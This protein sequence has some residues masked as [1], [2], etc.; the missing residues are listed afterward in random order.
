[1][2]L[3]LILSAA[4]HPARSQPGSSFERERGLIMLDS[5]KSDLKKN[6]YDAN[7]HGMDL[8]ARFKQAEEKIKQAASNGQ[9]FSIIAQ[10]LSELEDSHTFFLPPSR[11]GR[12]DYGWQMQ[13][14]GDKCY[15]TAIRP[16]SDAE[17]K[18]L[19]LG[20]EVWTIDGFGLTRENL[21]KLKY[22]YYSLK[23]RGGMRVVVKKPDGQEQQLDVMA[24]VVSGK[25]VI[26]LTGNDIVQFIR[27]AESEDRL[28]RHRYYE[29]GDELMIWK[30]PQFDLTDL[31]VDEIM[32]KV[33]KRKALV[34]DLRGNGGG[35]ISTLQRLVGNL[36]D[37]DIKIGDVK[38]RNEMK[39]QVG[40]T[41][42]QKAY[43]GKLV[44]LVD[45]ES[46][47]ASELFA[48]IVQLEKRGTVIGD[49]TAGAVM[50]SKHYSHQLGIDTIA[51]YGVSVTNA[52][53]IMSDGKSLEHMGVT[54]D[55]VLLP[56][57]ADMAARR[58][59]VLA[60]AAAL[61][62]LTLDPDKAGTFFPVEWRK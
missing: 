49:R 44:V 39:P 40:K 3:L 8:T 33:R 27:E 10:L 60:R 62:G 13:M 28:H 14:I 25:Q 7:F 51:L 30:M 45:S 24:K 32:D 19:K 47:S 61:L 35:A 55:E 48:R 18:G 56:T 43:Q 41:R 11:V 53:V 26:D 34:L 4:F 17:A 50:V 5:V 15:V 21:W 36:F 59:P 54:P 46:G 12:T 38:G 37:R 9:I 58:D 23:P 16:K 22:I 20:D 2:P 29:L 42:G 31:G 57:P 6:Y 52:D 1:L